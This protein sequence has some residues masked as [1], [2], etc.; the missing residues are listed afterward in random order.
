MKLIVSA[1]T[2]QGDTHTNAVQTAAL[3]SFVASHGLFAELVIGS[4]DGNREI[5]IAVEGFA[6]VSHMLVTAAT[7]MVQFN[8]QAVYYTQDGNAY[9]AYRDGRTELLGKEVARR[10]A[11]HGHELHPNHT[12]YLDGTMITAKAK[13]VALKAA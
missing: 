6:S 5:A 9:L 7:M 4:F 8:Q 2:R 1:F 12:Q 11:W 3:T 13:T 10:N